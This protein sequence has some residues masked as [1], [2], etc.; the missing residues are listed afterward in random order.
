MENHTASSTT[1]CDSYENLI[2]LLQEVM[3]DEEV[4]EVFVS[5]M[6]PS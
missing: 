3:E 2:A 5:I 6:F 1:S 4:S